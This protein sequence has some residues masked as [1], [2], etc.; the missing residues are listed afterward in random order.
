MNS[1][2]YA[3]Y[4]ALRNVYCDNSYSNLAINEALKEYKVSSQGFVRV[5]SKGVIRDTILLDYNIDRLAKNGIK[6]IKK[7]H[8]I[9]LRMGMYAMAKMDSVPAYAAVNEAVSLAEKISPTIKGFINGMLRAFEREGSIILVPDTDDELRLLSYRYSF[10]YHLVRFIFKQYGKEA[11][12]GIIKGLYDIPELNI[13]VNSFT[14]NRDDLKKYLVDRGITVRDNPLARNGIIIENGSV[15]NIPEFKSGMFT[16]Q[17]TSSLR[18]V[19]VLNPK[20]GDNVLDMCA[21]PGGKSTA[22]AEMMNDTGF[23]LACDIHDHRVRLIKELSKRLGLSSIKTKVMDA[24]LYN[25]SLC[26]RFDK[27]LADVPCSGL[28]IIAGKPELKL[29][30]DLNE[31]P[32]LYEIQYSILKNAFY[33]L[34]TGGELLYSTCTINKRENE[35]IVSRLCDS[36]ENSSIV[37]YNSILPYNKQVGFYY[38]KIKKCSN[39]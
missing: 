39:L 8:L 28:G 20:P 18:S 11:I 33:Y 22:M 14:S 38:C 6:G 24:T 19:E 13:R 16:V 21:A 10:P 2:W 37:E 27:V 9:I 1:D 7:K 12:E 29:H 32:S 17:S 34:K 5:M 4:V 15:V 36:F 30:V 26:E 25:E 23:I 35:H 31:L 3:V